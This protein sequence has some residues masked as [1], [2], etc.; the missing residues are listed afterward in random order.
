MRVFAAQSTLVTDETARLHGNREAEPTRRNR[1]MKLSPKQQKAITLLASGTSKRE[2]AEAVGVTP[3]TISE[4]HRNPDF[5]AARNALQRDQLDAART[6]LQ[7]LAKDAASTLSDV[8]RNADSHETRRRA[9]LDVL[10]MAGLAGDRD[11]FGWGI[12][13]DTAAQIEK[14]ARQKEK[15][16]AVFEELMGF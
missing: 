12:G 7:A 11:R 13:P 4:W 6:H 14:D 3:Q 1:K 9:A 10:E 15:Q 5:Q 2:T 8:M 16:D